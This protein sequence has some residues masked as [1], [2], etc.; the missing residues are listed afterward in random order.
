MR[1]LCAADLHIG[2]TS[3]RL[4]SAS[5][6]SDFTCS[7]AW[8]RI[9][10]CALSQNIDCLVLAGDIVDRDNSR[11]E[12]LDS[13]EK[14]LH[15]LSDA[16]IRIYAVS[17]NHDP[18]TLEQIASGLDIP[19][20]R[21]LGLDGNWESVDDPSGLRVLGRSYSKVDELSNPIDSFPDVLNDSQPT[22][23]ILHS[24]LSSTA[25]TYAPTSISELAS[26]S[27][28][29]WVVGHIHQGSGSI[30]MPSRNVIVPGSPQALNPRE[31]GA[32]GVCIASYEGSSTPELEFIPISSMRYE[33][34]NVPLDGVQSEMEIPERIRSSVQ[35]LRLEAFTT[36]SNLS[37][38]SLRVT[39]T[40]CTPLYNCIRS[41]VADLAKEGSIDLGPE[42]Q[43]EKFKLETGPCIDL[44]SLAK[45]EDI[46]ARLASLIKSIDSGEVTEEYQAL[47]QTCLDYAAKTHTK[48][49]F[50]PISFQKT[51]EQEDQVPDIDQI[52]AVVRTQA[53]VLLSELIS[54]RERG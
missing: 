38:L 10:Q 2:R 37:L 49:A 12:A 52:T 53:M 25:G 35:P 18:Q 15:I 36:N 5:N 30:W 28:V 14:G 13:L 48:P 8:N 22:I 21:M 43:L 33:R 7:N 42:I 44:D 27:S 29:T 1:V 51:G 11:F 46:S 16:N 45:A 3:T 39:F 50:S 24:N 6:P 26:Y 9:V 47:L 41:I 23:A 20:F 17:G 40:G 19:N 54:Q 32:H 34:L 4:P 31:S